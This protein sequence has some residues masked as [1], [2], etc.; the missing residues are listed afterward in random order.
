MMGLGL[1]YGYVLTLQ[2]CVQCQCHRQ[3]YLIQAHGEPLPGTYD[4]VAK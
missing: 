1:W 3:R 2:L 4:E